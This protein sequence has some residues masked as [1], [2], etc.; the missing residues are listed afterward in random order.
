MLLLMQLEIL[1]Q[2]LIKEY[3]ELDNNYNHFD[4][5]PYFFYL[6]SILGFMYIAI[7]FVKMLY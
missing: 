3:H 2:K 1:T 4:N 6:G 5:T 7:S